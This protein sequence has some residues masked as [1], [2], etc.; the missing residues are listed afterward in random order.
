MHES[1]REQQQVEHCMRDDARVETRATASRTLHENMRGMRNDHTKTV[2]RRETKHHTKHEEDHMNGRKEKHERPRNSR[3]RK[4]QTKCETKS[5]TIEWKKEPHQR[6]RREENGLQAS[7]TQSK[8]L[9]ASR[10]SYNE[11][12]SDT[13]QNYNGVNR[14]QH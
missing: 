10:T 6:E 11:T 13:T 7:S 12:E 14:K 4:Q 3:E 8:V 2:N 5:R 1:R 9:C